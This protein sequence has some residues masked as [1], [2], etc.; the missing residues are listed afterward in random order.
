MGKQVH[1]PH[2]STAEVLAPPHLGNG[3]NPTSIPHHHPAPLR[4]DALGSSDP[5]SRAPKQQGRASV[6]ERE[7]WSEER[8]LFLEFIP[9]PQ[10]QLA[11]LFRGHGE[12]P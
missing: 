10:G 2:P 8:S 7:G 12:Y 11:K 9:L 6:T 4:D 1:V 5:S 3:D